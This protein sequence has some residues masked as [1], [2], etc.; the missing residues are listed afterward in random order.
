MAES[1]EPKDPPT[2]PPPEPSRKLHAFNRSGVPA[3][4]ALAQ[5]DLLAAFHLPISSLD[6]HKPTSLDDA[7]EAAARALGE[8]LL[9]KKT[10][11]RFRALLNSKNDKMALAAF[12]L[13][14]QHILSVAKPG[15][16]DT[17]PTQIIVNNLV[18]RPKD[19]DVTT[20]EVH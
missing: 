3:R 12:E 1:D 9:Q 11:R 16:G 4:K 14:I 13:A 10:L 17:K 18:A 19:P 6:N 8:I 2:P 7:R 20:V 15:T 5:K